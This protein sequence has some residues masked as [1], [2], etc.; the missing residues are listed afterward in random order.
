MLGFLPFLQVNEEKIPLISV[1]CRFLAKEFNLAG[2]SNIE[3]VIEFEI[4][5]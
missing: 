1:I 3:Q 2:D 4:N 5:N